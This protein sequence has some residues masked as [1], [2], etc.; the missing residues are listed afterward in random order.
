MFEP[1]DRVM[2]KNR[3]GVAPR[4]TV[5]S[6]QDHM[7]SYI[8]PT[9]AEVLM[10]LGGSG[11]AGPMGIPAFPE[12]GM[13]GGQDD[14]DPASDP[15]GIGGTDPA[16][17]TSGGGSSGDSGAGEGGDTFSDDF[18]PLATVIGGTRDALTGA[19]ASFGPGTPG[20]RD[21]SDYGGYEDDVLASQPVGGTGVLSAQDSFN[22]ARGITIDNPYGYDGFFSRTFG[23][24]PSKISYANIMDVNNRANIANNQFSKFVNPTNT[25]GRIGY[26]PAFP[27]AEPGFLRSGVQKEGFNTILGPVQRYARQRSPSD[28]I[29]AAAFGPFGLIADQL[30][31]DT[32]GVGGIRPPDAAAPGQPT[33]LLGQAVQ[34]IRQGVGDLIGRLT[35]KEQEKVA[36]SGGR[37]EVVERDGRNVMVFA[38]GSEIDLG[39]GREVGVDPMR[40][41]VFAT[42]PAFFGQKREKG[43]LQRGFDAL[44]RM[45]AR[46]KISPEVDAFLSEHGITTEQFLDPDSFSRALIEQVPDGAVLPDGKVMSPDLREEVINDF[47]TRQETDSKPDIGGMIQDLLSSADPSAGLFTPVADTT[48]QRKR[49]GSQNLYVTDKYSTTDE[50]INKFGLGSFFRGLGMDVARP[51]SVQQYVPRTQQ[52][53]FLGNLFP[54]TATTPAPPE[55]AFTPAAQARRDAQTLGLASLEDLVSRNIPMG[56]EIDTR[57][58]RSGFS[59]TPSEREFQQLQESFGGGPDDGAVGASGASDDGTEFVNYQPKISGGYYDY[60]TVFDNMPLRPPIQDGD[61]RDRIADNMPLPDYRI[62]IPTEEIL[63]RLQFFMDPSRRVKM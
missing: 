54:T 41:S 2:K 4:R 57:T 31:K 10:Q 44:G 27:P 16:G 36:E 28:M 3:G 48:G 30:T 6:G 13:G 5:I 37:Y 22:Q 39:R 34:G 40:D 8:T 55:S 45:D 17:D 46:S 29:A 59:L 35:P 56:P 38:D 18:D 14:S 20:F 42:D 61:G 12:P 11:E 50:L 19:P 60:D 25:P 21:T 43:V 15:G 32:F 63:N 23:I 9:E 53:S 52:R 24:H 58:Q 26:N 7:L 47:N 49:S 1:I 33:S 62:V 51:P